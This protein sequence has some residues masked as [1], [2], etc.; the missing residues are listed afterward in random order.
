M[1][2]PYTQARKMNSANIQAELYRRCY[3]AGLECI[4]EHRHDK[5]RF[6]AIIVKDG[7]IKVIIEVKNHRRDYG[8]KSINTKQLQKYRSYGVPVMLIRGMSDLDN[9]IKWLSENIR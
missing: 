3:M 9:S 6:D 2:L 7:E 5:S 1:S 4:L 8:E